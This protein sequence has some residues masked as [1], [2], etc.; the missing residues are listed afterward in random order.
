[1]F[2]QIIQAQVRDRGAAISEGERWQREV[3]PQAAGFL[4]STGGVTADGR[5]IIVA[6]FES[7]EAARRNSDRDEQGEWWHR[8]S[9]NIQGDAIFHES[10]DV[11]TY[12]G[13]GD[14]SAGF[15]QVMQGRV[16]DVEAARRLSEKMEEQMPATRPDILGGL[17]ATYDDGAFTD[18]VYFTSMEESRRNEKAMSD[19]PPTAMEEWAELLDGEITYYDLEEPQLVSR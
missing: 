8:V 9:S 14:D 6:R 3:M 18:V 15:V 5:L 16:K 1:M 17:T 11:V 2:V 13:G 19:D 4:G 7:E 10:S 12:R